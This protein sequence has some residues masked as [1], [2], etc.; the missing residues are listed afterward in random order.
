L[1][2]DYQNTLL[3]LFSKSNFELNEVVG[4]IESVLNSSVIDISQDPSTSFKLRKFYQ[5]LFF[6]DVWL[7]PVVW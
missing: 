7:H 3:G 6:Y 1:S 2:P 4:Y 5:K